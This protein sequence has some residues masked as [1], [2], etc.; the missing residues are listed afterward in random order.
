MSLKCPVN[1]N[2]ASK[3]FGAPCERAKHGIE[4]GEEEKKSDSGVI[5]SC[6]RPSVYMKALP[7]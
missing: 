1:G 6:L 5:F 2:F 4:T 7:D 3:I